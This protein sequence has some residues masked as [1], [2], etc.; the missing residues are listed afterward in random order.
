VALFFGDY[1]QDIV[2]NFMLH[3]V[4][5]GVDGW[6]AGECGGFWAEKYFINLEA[7]FILLP[8]KLNPKSNNQ[9]PIFP[10]TSGKKTINFQFNYN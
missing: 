9:P 8:E 2:L 10:S 5:L 4:F 1:L 6:I 3:A 7:T